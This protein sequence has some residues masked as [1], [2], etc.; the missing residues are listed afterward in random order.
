MKISARQQ[1]NARNAMANVSK[2]GNGNVVLIAGCGKTYADIA[3]RF[4]KSERSLQEIIASEY[5]KHI[6]KNI[7]D[8]G[9]YSALEFD[10]FLFG[11]EGYSRITETQL[12]RK[13]LASYMIKSGRIELKGKRSFNVV[14]PDSLLDLTVSYNG[15]EYNTSDVID[16]IQ[17]WYDF[18]LAQGIKEEDLRYL[19][20]LAAE[21]K[22]IIGMNAHALR[23][24]FEVRC[25]Q[26]AQ[27]EIRDLA[28]KMLKLCK[29][30][31]PDLFE[32]AGASCVKLG[33]CPHNNLQSDK[34]K[35]KIITHNEVLELLN[36][37]RR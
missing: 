28:N 11:Y 31:K 2:V 30:A 22:G 19:K 8:A 7:L 10:Y 1:I 23:D 6:I 21:S 17:T 26:C 9:H 20:P 4:V 32:K 18:G 37:I 35:G 5:D 33:Y 16:L 13:R 27:D 34:C 36:D 3:A 14:M 24:F 29:E 25:C 15:Q 12:V